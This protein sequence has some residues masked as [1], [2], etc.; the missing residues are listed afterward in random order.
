MLKENQETPP[1][2][3]TEVAA[4]IPACDLEEKVFEGELTGTPEHKVTRK[5]IMRV[6]FSGPLPPPDILQRYKDIQSD[7]PERI[8]RLTESEAAHR[9]EVTTQTVAIDKT[10]TILGQVFG[11]IVTLAAFACAA[12]LGFHDHSTAASIVGGSTIAGLVTAFITGR[13]SQ[14]QNNKNGKEAGPPKKSD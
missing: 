5:D 13:S 4:E 11:L 7:L 8:L 14:Q 6:S 10:E 9:R 12:F 3:V 2:E 1:E